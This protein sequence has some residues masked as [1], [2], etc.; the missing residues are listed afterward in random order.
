[1]MDP[2][3]YD[4][5]T[6]VRGATGLMTGEGDPSGSIDF[7]R[8]RPT[9]EF[10][11][12]AG[13]ALGRWQRKRLEYDVSGTLLGDGLLRGRLVA[14]RDAA[15]DSW[16]ERHDGGR[17]TTVYGVLD[18]HLSKRTVAS[19]S[20]EYAE[21]KDQQAPAWGFPIADAL[22]RPTTF[23]R[24]QNSAH[25]QDDLDVSRDM[26]AASLE[27]VFNNGWRAKVSMNKTWLNHKQDLSV[28]Y[29]DLGEDGRSGLLWVWRNQNTASQQGSSARLSGDY[30]MWGRQHQFFAA[31]EHQSLD[32]DDPYHLFEWIPI[33]DAYAY[34]GDIPRPDLQIVG[35]ITQRLRRSSAT[36]SSRLS[37]TPALSLIGGL[38]VGRFHQESSTAGF[39]SEIEEDGITTPYF[40]AVYDFAD[41]WTAYSS[42]TSIFNPQSNKDREGRFLA[43]EEGINIELGLRKALLNDK[44][45]LNTALYHSKKDNLALIDTG[46]LTPSGEQAY[47]AADYTKAH[48]YELELIGEVTPRW[49]VSAGYTW[50][51]I[52]DRDKQRLLRN[53]PNSKFTLFTTYRTSDAVTLGGGLNWYASMKNT[54]HP[55]DQGSYAVANLM[56]RYAFNKQLNLSLD[57]SNLF[58]KSYLTT[59]DFRNYGEPRRWQLAVRYQF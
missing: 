14:V 4:R 38:R 43:P 46:N 32:Q 3:I 41:S 23:G 13:F 8:K 53:V 45:T 24:E 16:I 48:G 9:R 40:G 54:T 15:D 17:K 29:G 31:L 47:R 59:V 49:D 28:F 19:L 39:D 18:A 30:T 22:G 1:M 57:I 21:F 51:R 6:V 35:R 58:D 10:F 44:L 27:H 34:D 2:A 50:N 26:A 42:Y 52:E 56:M 25:R 11:S 36:L 12:Q 37:V 5:I 7:V 55:I 33:E 20:L